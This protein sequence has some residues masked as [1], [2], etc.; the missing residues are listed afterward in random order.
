GGVCAGMAAYWDDREDRYKA[1]PSLDPDEIAVHWKVPDKQ[2]ALAALDQ[3]LTALRA[4][5]IA[6]DIDARRRRTEMTVLEHRFPGLPSRRR[7]PADPGAPEL[8]AAAKAFDDAS[9]AADLSAALASELLAE[10][11]KLE[12]DKL[13]ASGEL[14][15]AQRDAAADLPRRKRADD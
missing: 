1:D 15:K 4:Q 13:R 9:A 11:E 6:A 10:A 3:R 5:G 14:H 7:R 12:G 2:A 8:A